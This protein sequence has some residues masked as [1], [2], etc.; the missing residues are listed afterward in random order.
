MADMQ[1]KFDAIGDTTWDER[2]GEAEGDDL[3]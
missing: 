3:L 2:L 1:S